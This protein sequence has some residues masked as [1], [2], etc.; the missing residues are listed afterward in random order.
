M[1]RTVE[2]MVASL[3]C[4]AASLS[5][6]ASCL[7]TTKAFEASAASIALTLDDA[8]RQ[9]LAFDPRVSQSWAEVSARAAGIDVARAAYLPSAHA[10]GQV[11]RVNDLS[12]IDGFGGKADAVR[13]TGHWRANI[14]WLLL[15]FGSRSARLEQARSR[16]AVATALQDVRLQQVIFDVARAYYAAVE[17]QSQLVTASRGESVAMRSAMAACARFEAGV[18]ALADVLRARTA[19]ARHALVR[20]NARAKVVER[21]GALAALIGID[22]DT[23]FALAREEFDGAYPPDPLPP[24]EDL[25]AELRQHHPALREAYAEIRAEASGREAIQHAWGPSVTLVGSVN[26]EI[27]SGSFAVERAGS[28]ARIGIQISIPLYDGG[29]RKR[30]AREADAMVDLV[31]AKTRATE[32]NLYSRIWQTHREMR[33]LSLSRAFEIRLYDDAKQSYEI[34]RGRYQEGIGNIEELMSAQN[35]LADAE[36]AMTVSRSRWHLAKLTLAASLGQLGVDGK[37]AFASPTSRRPLLGIMQPTS[38]P[39][40]DRE[41]GTAARHPNTQR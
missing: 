23:V 6:H 12:D 15:D 36:R 41:S 7:P 21:S 16:L 8:V 11:S 14:S 22:M 1:I 25:M 37:P 33:A 9:A 39:P 34:A 40:P 2:W 30:R 35:V 38:P 13:S 3:L 17:A 26:Q 10:G 27:G 19:Y 20:L 32:R 18:G 31:R 24:V 28:S 29:L 4:V 5:V